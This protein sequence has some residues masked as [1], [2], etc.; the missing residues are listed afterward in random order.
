MNNNRNGLILRITPSYKYF[1]LLFPL[2]KPDTFDSLPSLH[3]VSIFLDLLKYTIFIVLLIR[4]FV[5]KK[6]LSLISL[7]YPAFLLV[8]LI[9]T[10]LNHNGNTVLHLFSTNIDLFIY[11][12]LANYVEEKDEYVDF[13]KAASF[14]LA[15]WCLANTL[16]VLAFYHRRYMYISNITTSIK[17]DRYLLGS[18]NYQILFILPM[19]SIT[20][21]LDVELVGKIRVRTLVIHILACVPLFMTAAATSIITMIIFYVLLWIG[22]KKPVILRMLQIPKILV[23]ASI[24]IF[25][26]FVVM[27]THSGIA[28][29][30]EMAFKKSIQSQRS[31]IWTSYLKR[32]SEKPLWGYGYMTDYMQVLLTRVVHAHN[33]YL[34]I[35]FRGGIIGI[36]VFILFIYSLLELSV[37]LNSKSGVISCAAASAMI[38]AFQGD[39]YYSLFFYFAIVILLVHGRINS[40]RIVI[41][42]RGL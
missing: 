32:I 29:L 17:K 36:I 15:F 7:I 18:K 14:L 1:L 41:G 38:V 34:Q 22:I 39:Y 26:M 6:N 4:F 3:Y 19:A 8:L 37:N 31:L 2:F 30:L 28:R 20:S 12:L 16:S 33:Q 27:G 5:Y 21:A 35:M 11:F 25:G 23:I 10:F 40:Q 24:A 13:L 9:S 42:N